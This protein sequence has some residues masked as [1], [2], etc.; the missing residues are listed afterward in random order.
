MNNTAGNNSTKN[1][2]KNAGNGNNTGN[3]N[4][5]AGNGNNAAANANAENRKLW[6]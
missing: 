6:K 3:A 2:G 5:P 1:V 4:K